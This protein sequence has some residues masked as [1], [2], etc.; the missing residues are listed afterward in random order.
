MAF[1]SVLERPSIGIAGIAGVGRP[2]AL[3][4]SVGTRLRLGLGLLILLLVATWHLAAAFAYPT[5]GDGTLRLSGSDAFVL[6]GLMPGDA[7]APVVLTLH[8]NGPVR[9]RVHIA[10]TGSLA[11]ASQAMLTL[12]VAGPGPGSYRGALA[13]AHLGGLGAGSALD[14]RLEAGQTAT[15]TIAGQVPLSAG[16][17]LQGAE[18]SARVIVDSNSPLD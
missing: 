17:E 3:R 14:L 7:I 6:A 4:V 1:A 11:L 12:D 5:E 9:Y 15:L 8:A 16:N 18:L 13:D 2:T 10:W